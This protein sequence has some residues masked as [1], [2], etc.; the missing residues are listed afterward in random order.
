M[1]LVEGVALDDLAVQAVHGK[2]HPR[3][4][5][6]GVALLLA[7]EGD[8]VV[9][10]LVSHF[11]DEVA[12]LHEHAGRA[13]G[14]VEHHAVVRFD[15]IDDHAHQRGRREELAAF[16][17]AALRELVEEVFV[18]AAE[19]IAGGTPQGFAVE[20]FDDLSQQIGL[21]GGVAARQ[22]PLEDFDLVLDALHGIVDGLADLGAL[23]QRRQCLEARLLWKVDGGLALETEADQLLALR[24]R[25]LGRNVS[26][27]LRQIILEAVVGMA[28]KDQA[29]HRHRIFGGGEFG[30]GAQLIGGLPELFFQMMQMGRHR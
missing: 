30:I 21:E 25:H 28:Q 29:E 23:R 2:V 7:V 1:I 16:L 13:A 22:C 6:V 18:D 9:C 11:L 12:G 27:D 15:D 20:D 26:S 8:F 3:Q 19:D 5:G 4:L 10:L 24:G 14:R 17:R